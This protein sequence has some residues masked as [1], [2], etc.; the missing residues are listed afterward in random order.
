MLK[1]PIKRLSALIKLECGLFVFLRK[2]IEIQVKYGD[3]LIL[4]VLGMDNSDATRT[5]TQEIESRQE[6]RRS[7]IDKGQQK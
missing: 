4:Y 7:A 3:V 6:S 5:P 1:I 2:R